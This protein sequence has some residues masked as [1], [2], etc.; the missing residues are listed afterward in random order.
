MES[1]RSLCVYY[2]IGLV[3]GY[4]TKPDVIRWADSVIE[5]GEFPYELIDVSLSANR[6]LQ[7]TA[8]ILKR[9]YNENR[10]VESLFK[11]VGKLVIGLEATRISDEDFFAYIGRLYWQ[12]EAFLMDEELLSIL[13][14]LDDGY[15]LATDGIGD[16]ETLR[17]E[18]LEQLQCYKDY[19]DFFEQTG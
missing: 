3:I 11:L 10:T 1:I 19:A 13:D 8:S 6:S 12:R 17:S 16:V 2:Y 15:Y 4:F 5:N 14:R 7:E 18:A 9:A